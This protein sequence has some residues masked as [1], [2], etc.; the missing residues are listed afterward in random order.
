MLHKT[1]PTIGRIDVY[2]CSSRIHLIDENVFT[3]KPQK[4]FNY[5]NF[6]KIPFLQEKFLSNEKN[7]DKMIK[8]SKAISQSQKYI[9][10]PNRQL[11]R[12]SR[13]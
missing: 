2:S 3:E 1:Y 9:M 10:W 8:T 4:I 7:M 11:I 5:Q 12:Q 6:L 13:Y